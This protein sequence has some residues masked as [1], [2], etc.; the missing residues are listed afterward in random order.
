MNEV[1]LSQLNYMLCSQLTA[2]RDTVRHETYRVA[3]V[4]REV[5][6]WTVIRSI[7][8]E[9]DQPL[10]HY[11]DR[12]SAQSA[13]ERLV[14][15][16]ADSQSS[17][18]KY[19]IIEEGGAYKVRITRLGGFVQE[20]DDFSTRADAASW[21]AEDQRIAGMEIKRGSPCSI[22]QPL[23][24]GVWAVVGAGA[25]WPFITMK[26]EAVTCWTRRSAV[27]RAISND[28]SPGPV[29]NSVGQRRHN[30]SKRPRSRASCSLPKV[31]A[32]RKLLTSLATFSWEWYRSTR[33]KSW[34]RLWIEHAT[35]ESIDNAL[36]F[37]RDRRCPATPAGKEG[38][39]ARL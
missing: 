13:W 30:Q 8:G 2:S 15:E 7:A 10:G 37:V 24:G 23:A 31:C 38:E 18:T 35:S 14:A 1:H 4:H 12:A 21:I 32:V 6:S 22:A 25:G 3:Q 16:E 17:D 39:K 28:L 5:D 11:P 9:E 20:A 27:I 34:S 26:P 33:C 29:G 19:E 36:A